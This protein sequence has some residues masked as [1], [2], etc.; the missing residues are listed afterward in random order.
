L[1][2]GNTATGE[3]KH[4][5]GPILIITDQKTG[6]A[7]EIEKTS[8]DLFFSGSVANGTLLECIDYYKNL[9]TR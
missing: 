8:Q 9:T 7:I 3:I 1:I 6:K 5:G 2:S 4:F